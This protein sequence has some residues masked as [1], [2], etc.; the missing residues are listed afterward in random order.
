MLVFILNWYSYKKKLATIVKVFSRRNLVVCLLLLPL[1]S[2]CALPTPEVYCG[3]LEK[4]ESEANQNLDELRTTTA[5]QRSSEEFSQNEK[6]E[7]LTSQNPD[8]ASVDESELSSPSLNRINLHIDG[9]GSMLGYVSIPESAYLNTLD[10]LGILFSFGVADVTPS[11]YRLGR[12]KNLGDRACISEKTNYCLSQFTDLN[13]AKESEFYIGGTEKFP[14]LTSSLHTAIPNFE[15]NKSDEA[16]E[17]EHQDFSDLL[18]VIVT[19]LEPDEAAVGNISRRLKPYLYSKKGYSVGILA[20]RSEFDGRVYR[21]HPDQ[22]F[23]QDLPNSGEPEDPNLSQDLPDSCESEDLDCFNYS[24]R[25]N[26][27]ETAHS[28]TDEPDSHTIESDSTDNGDP[29]ID[30]F[31]PFYILFLGQNKFVSEFIEKI[32]QE[33]KLPENQ[34]KATIFNPA[35]S[36]DDFVYL[37]DESDLSDNLES[38]ESINDGEVIVDRTDRFRFFKLKSDSER[39]E[40]YIVHNEIPLHLSPYALSPTEFKLTNVTIALFEDE[41]GK[42]VLEPISDAIPEDYIDLIELS[43]PEQREGNNSS[44]SNEGNLLRFKT[45]IHP[46]MFTSSKVYMIKADV[47][48]KGLADASWWEDFDWGS[49]KSEEDG[50]KTYNLIQFLREIRL[51]TVSAKDNGAKPIGKFC[52]GIYKS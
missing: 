17:T 21:V 20:I 43:P 2:S 24:T 13:D 40:T 37:Q 45:V 39:Q 28:S 48:A 52:Y 33:L 44:E 10:S 4:D 31:R 1:I 32:I 29:N 42:K 36:V 3:V 22:Q 8:S 27:G 7:A 41:T 51:T 6:I 38:V 47:I 35:A 14:G 16:S 19:D 18:S 30:G 25:S 34:I 5:N 12:P 46:D 11:F 15:S 49:S 50:S 9:S 26:A 23:S